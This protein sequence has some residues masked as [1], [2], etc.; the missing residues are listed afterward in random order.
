MFAGRRSSW[1]SSV[2]LRSLLYQA[3]H[4]LSRARP[5]RKRTLGPSTIRASHT[6]AVV[7]AGSVAANRQGNLQATLQQ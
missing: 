3:V 4:T 5:T 7:S 2:G 1:C 6:R